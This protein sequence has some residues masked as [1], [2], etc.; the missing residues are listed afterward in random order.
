M[1]LVEKLTVFLFSLCCEIPVKVSVVPVEE[2]IKR[3]EIVHDFVRI[4]EMLQSSLHATV[5]LMCPSFEVETDSPIRELADE[6]IDDMG[7]HFEVTIAIS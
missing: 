7:D 6:L 5:N 2:S 4:L 3:N 1:L